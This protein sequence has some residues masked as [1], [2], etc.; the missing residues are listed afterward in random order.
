MCNA[1][2]AA[3]SVRS[4][5]LPRCTAVMFCSFAHA[6]SALEKSPSGPMSMLQLACPLTAL[7]KLSFGLSSQCAIKVGLLTSISLSGVKGSSIGA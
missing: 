4:L 3:V 7:F 1:A 5:F 6:I 2:N